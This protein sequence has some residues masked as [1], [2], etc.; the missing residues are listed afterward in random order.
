M[1][2][3]GAAVEGW[4]RS[5][6]EEAVEGQV[7]DRD[8]ECLSTLFAQ[9]TILT[10]MDGSQALACSSVSLACT[11]NLSLLLL[12]DPHLVHLGQRRAVSWLYTVA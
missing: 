11:Q 8:G 6:R 2:E 1:W 7:C 5:S 3:G 12:L 10:S 4:W 9:L